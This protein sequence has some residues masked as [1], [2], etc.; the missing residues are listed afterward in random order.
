MKAVYS[1]TKMGMVTPCKMYILDTKY[2]IYS[3]HNWKNF[4]FLINLH[5]QENIPLKSQLVIW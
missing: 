4:K 1:D 2:C 3:K 5:M